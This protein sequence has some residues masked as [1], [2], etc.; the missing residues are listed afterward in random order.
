MT[1]PI[2]EQAT[3]N[4]P[5]EGMLT[6]RRHDDGLYFIIKDRLQA[7]ATKLDYQGVADLVTSI[8]LFIEPRLPAPGEG[9][10]NTPDDAFVL[11][12]DRNHMWVGDNGEGFVSHLS[13]AGQFTN[14]QFLEY[15]DR[16]WTSTKPTDIPNLRIIPVAYIGYARHY[17]PL[18][19]PRGITP[20]Q[21]G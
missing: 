12:N 5:M 16:E 11:W 3:P 9:V 7:M 2:F 10:T 21:Q 20:P 4:D 1:P 17:A 18:E 13:D 6:V 8:L 19:V 15:L 14:D